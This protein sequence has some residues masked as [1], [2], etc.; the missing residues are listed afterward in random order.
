MVLLAQE[1]V[2][3]IWTIAGDLVALIRKNRSI[4]LLLRFVESNTEVN[5]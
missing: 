2:E 4:L 5:K 1:V 3:V